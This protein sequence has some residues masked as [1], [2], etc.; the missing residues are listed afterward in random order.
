MID[1]LLNAAI[2]LIVFIIVAFIF[3]RKDHNWDLQ[4][5][6]SA[7]RFFTAQSN[8]LCAVTALLICIYPESHLAWTLKY[9][10]TVAVTVTMLTVFL[11]LAP[12][13]GK[14]GLKQLLKD[15]DLFLHLIVPLL[16]L[17]SFCIYEKRGMALG[18]AL[19]GMLPVALYGPWYLYKTNYAPE[20]KRWNDFYGFNKDG[21]WPISFTMMFICTLLIC[22]GLKALQNV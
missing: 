4:R 20:D 10:G 7:M 17:L 5:G 1:F 2:F 15:A 22:L 19:L 3:F 16:A 9:I 6:R 18:T 11:F 14:G 21:K 8:V 13:I 12:S